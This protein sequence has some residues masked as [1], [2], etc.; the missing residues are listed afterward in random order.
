MNR[1][2]RMIRISCIGHGLNGD[3]MP[4]NQNNTTNM[5]VLYIG[6]LLIAIVP[7]I[8]FVAY[9]EVRGKNSHF[10]ELSVTDTFFDNCHVFHSANGNQFALLTLPH[11]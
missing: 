6:I 2:T 7:C 11:H 3:W 10:L 8:S 5:Q 4:A 9:E 1:P